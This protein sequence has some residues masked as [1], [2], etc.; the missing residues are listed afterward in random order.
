M[1]KP[2]PTK[3]RNAGAQ[4]VKTRRMAEAL[5]DQIIVTRQAVKD[6]GEELRPHGMKAMD[7]ARGLEHLF[8][9]MKSESHIGQAHCIFRAELGRC[10]VA[11][12]TDDDIIVIL[13]GGGGGR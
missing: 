4:M 3:T 6:A 8:E 7:L 2:C 11:E 12:P 1:P 13:G 5:V 10:D 9:A